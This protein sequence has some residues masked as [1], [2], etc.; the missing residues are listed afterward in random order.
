MGFDSLARV[1]TAANIL[2]HLA[3]NQNQ[4]VA[5][6]LPSDLGR[7]AKEVGNNLHDLSSRK[8]HPRMDGALELGSGQG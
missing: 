5:N 2:C 8:G 3:V 6:V 7:A 4:A 1:E